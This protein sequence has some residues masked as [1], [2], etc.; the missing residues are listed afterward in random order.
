MGGLI[1]DIRIYT[2]TRTD[3]LIRCPVIGFAVCSPA[4]HSLYV[5][6]YSFSSDWN[7]MSKFVPNQSSASDYASRTFGL[8]EMTLCRY[9]S[10]KHIGL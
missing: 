7:C 3:M 9:D 10:G 1:T 6:C 8:A 5:Q 4:F 2:D